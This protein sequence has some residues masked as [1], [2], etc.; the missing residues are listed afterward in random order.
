MHCQQHNERTEIKSFKFTVILYTYIGPF[1]KSLPVFEQALTPSLPT[2]AIPST[3]YQERRLL[4]KEVNSF[5]WKEHPIPGRLSKIFISPV[6]CPLSDCPQCPVCVT[7]PINMAHALRTPARS[8]YSS[9]SERESIW[10]H[11]L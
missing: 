9:N 10:K 5:T 6:I 11:D 3:S 2:G 8:L 7:N 4:T 1:I